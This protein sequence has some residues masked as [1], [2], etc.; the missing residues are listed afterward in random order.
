MSLREFLIRAKVQT[1]ASEGERNERQ[2]EDGGKELTFRDGEYLYRDRY[3]GFN[4]FAGEEIVWRDGQAAWAMNYYGEVTDDAVPCVDVYRFLQ[5]ALRNVEAGRPFR[6]PREFS[7]GAFTYRD[8][9]TGDL[10]RF[11]GREAISYQGR[12]VYRLDYH[13]GNVARSEDS[14]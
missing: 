6:G 12:E 3:Y 4:P 5:S 10:D 7:D 11:S 9:S 1:Y 2:L 14:R 8:Q 13:G